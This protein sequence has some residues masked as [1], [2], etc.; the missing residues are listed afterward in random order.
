ME[1]AERPEAYPEK[2]SMVQYIDADMLNNLVVRTR[3]P[4]DVFTPFGM[5]GTKKLQDW[6]VDSKIPRELRD[7]LPLLCSDKKV[8][9][10]I[11]YSLGEALRVMSETRRIYKIFYSYASKED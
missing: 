5:A 6:F 1:L 10:V 2:G 9:W 11:G 8:L 3:R 7:S 4:G